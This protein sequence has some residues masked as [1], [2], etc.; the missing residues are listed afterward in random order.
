V[1]FF[2]RRGYSLVAG[3]AALAGAGNDPTAAVDGAAAAGAR[4]VLLFGGA[5]PPGSLGLAPT[6]DVPVVGLPRTT[7]REILRRLRAGERVGISIAGARRAPNT[8]LGHVAAFSSHGLAFDGRVKPDLVAPG[9]ALATAE[10]GVTE[11][12][13]T[14][15]GTVNGSS[16][17]A[18]VVAGAAALVAEARP[19]LDAAAL[20]SVLVGTA[21]PVTGDGV[22]AAGAG[23]VDVGAA[24]AAEV[25]AE[26]ATLAFGRA[27]GD[28][29]AAQHLRV[30]NLSTRQMNVFV[31]VRQ[32]VEGAAAV[33]FTVHPRRVSIPVGGDVAVTVRARVES[34][35]QGTTAAAGV[36]VLNPAGSA[37]VRVPWLIAFAPPA[38]DLIGRPR[39]S[40]SSFAP[41]DAAPAL[42]TFDAGAVKE[43][44]GHVEV[45]PLAEL[46]VRLYSSNGSLIGIL[47][48][49]RDLLPGR[50]QLGLT[51]RDPAGA[52]LPRGD[53]VI[54]LVG[55]PTLGGPLSQR[56]I[57]ITIK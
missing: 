53:Y 27:H 9:V 13:I 28:W 1:R 12:D 54:R 38:R 16:A 18:A 8:E 4:A 50:Y 33:R 49:L 15:Y 45:Q 6:T 14:R 23:I 36:V 41:S 39:L 19:A 47:A 42:L 55:R 22:N 5:L 48:R 57:R 20:K 31:S 40:A 35:P 10:P 7:A 11:R 21:R 17:A 43:R 25:G 29:H 51:G 32:D 52:V 37:P 30:R 2:D 46:E 26:P 34:A 44:G 56:T 24:T 3:H